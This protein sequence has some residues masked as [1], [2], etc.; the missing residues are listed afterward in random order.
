MRLL[1]LSI[2]IAPTSRDAHSPIAVVNHVS[3]NG[4][5]VTI[6]NSI[7]IV[8]IEIEKKIENKEVFSKPT[9]E[10]IARLNFAK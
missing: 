7:A 4:A 8:T 2:K 5:P 1:I 10:Q 6:F 9:V 3:K